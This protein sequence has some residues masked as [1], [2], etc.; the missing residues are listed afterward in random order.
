MLAPI[1]HNET[2]PGLDRAEGANSFLTTIPL[3]PWKDRDHD[4]VHR[5]AT[6]RN[7]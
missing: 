6:R 1:T 5:H 4:L 7:Q 3:T 2:A